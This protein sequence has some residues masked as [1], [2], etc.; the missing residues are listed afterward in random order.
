MKI[1]YQSFANIASYRLNFAL[2]SEFPA[3]RAGIKSDLPLV[4]LSKNR[5]TVQFFGLSLF[6]PRTKI[7]NQLRWNKQQKNLPAVVFIQRKIDRDKYA[8]H[9][10]GDYVV[11]VLAVVP[12]G[13]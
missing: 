8:A 13:I 6:Q 2:Y 7:H 3:G 10:R 5:I 12:Y 9:Q 4:E 1:L 11:V